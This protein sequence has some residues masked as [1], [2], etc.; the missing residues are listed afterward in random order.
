MRWKQFLTP[1]QSMDAEKAQQFISDCKP[2]EVNI[3]DVRQP[4]EYET[5]HLPGSK[6]IPVG[7]L[8]KR[9]DELDP[10]KP[11]LVY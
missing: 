9:I 10:E 8:G 7:D 6:L 4:G 5:G 3:L 11:T 2:S 1:V